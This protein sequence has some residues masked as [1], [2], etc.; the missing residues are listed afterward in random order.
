MTK[1][2][3]IDDNEAILEAV[4]IALDGSGYDVITST[5]GEDF[6]PTIAKI[7]PSVVLLD[8]LLSGEDGREVAKALRNN[9]DTKNIP[10]I[11][12]SADPGAEKIA[13][14]GGIDGFLSKP[15]D[16]DRLLAAVSDCVCD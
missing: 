7:K 5:K 9:K 8:L 15:F 11:L 14:D 13:K 16:L 2:V 3:I 10:I 1:I 6:I 4:K 12:I